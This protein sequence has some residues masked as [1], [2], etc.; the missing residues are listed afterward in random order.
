MYPFLWSEE[1]HED[2]AATTRSAV[3]MREVLG[4]AA[5]FARQAGAADPGFLGDV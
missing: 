3:P 5:D 2:L 1:A 4:V